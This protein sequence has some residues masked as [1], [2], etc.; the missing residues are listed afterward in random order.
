MRDY[1]I[2]YSYGSRFDP[3]MIPLYPPSMTS[4]ISKVS[5]ERTQQFGKVLFLKIRLVS[6]R[7]TSQSVDRLKKG[8]IKKPYQPILDFE[9]HY[10][11][12][13]LL[14]KPWSNKVPNKH[15]TL[16]AI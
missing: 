12:S 14:T 7:I 15:G 9:N 8:K 10:N 16:S 1:F 2:K 3:L 4:Y 5:S 6:F 13:F 11:C